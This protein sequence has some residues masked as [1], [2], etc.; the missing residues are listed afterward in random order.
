MRD[1]LIP[2]G[3]VDDRSIK[4]VAKRPEDLEGY[5]QCH[6][7]AGIGG[8]PLALMLAGVPDDFP[9]WTGSCPCQSFSV[10]AMGR[11]R[12]FKDPRG[13]LWKPFY[14]LIAARKPPL[15]FGEQVEGAID[16]GWLDLVAGDLGKAGYAVGAAV[17]PAGHVGAPHRRDR[18]YFV[19]DHDGESKTPAL[20]P[21][22]PNDEFDFNKGFWK[23]ATRVKCADGK[24]R[25]A[26]PLE[27]EGLSLLVGD[28]LP[29]SLVLLRGAGNAIVPQHAAEFISAFFEAKGK[30]RRPKA[31]A[32]SAGR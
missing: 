17:F 30:M 31:K 16:H 20:R 2:R 21:F 14:Q 13:K 32:A 24:T 7:F 9:L 4:E 1:G 25:L 12:G 10:A 28:G 6:F 15:V 8:W 26:P 27:A 29:G 23:D 22:G 5:D 3:D 11:Q 19:G 18:I